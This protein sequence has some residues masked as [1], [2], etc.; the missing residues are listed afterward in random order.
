MQLAAY[1]EISK[2]PIGPEA[3]APRSF[4]LQP[5]YGYPPGRD[6]EVTIRSILVMGNDHDPEVLCEWAATWR[7]PGKIQN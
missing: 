5:I 7:L 3:S 1:S 6:S 4:L 2:N